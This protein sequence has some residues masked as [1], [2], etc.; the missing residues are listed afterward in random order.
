[1]LDIYHKLV[2]YSYMVTKGVIKGECIKH[3]APKVFLAKE[4]QDV[5]IQVKTNTSKD[6]HV[7]LFTKILALVI[8]HIYC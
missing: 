3:I 7:D 2:M 5:L 4:Q 8:H 6:S 1:M